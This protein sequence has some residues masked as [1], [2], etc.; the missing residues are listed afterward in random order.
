MKT[1]RAIGS[2][3]C[4]ISCSIFIKDIAAI[5]LSSCILVGA[6]LQVP[7]LTTLSLQVLIMASIKLTQRVAKI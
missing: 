2:T 3:H 7:I 4:S 6:R 5:L 1:S